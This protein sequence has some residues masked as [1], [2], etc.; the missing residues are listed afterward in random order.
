MTACRVAK[1]GTSIMAQSVSRK[2]L[3][4]P[5]NH[6]KADKGDSADLAGESRLEGGTTQLVDPTPPL[7]A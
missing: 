3:A 4:A 5:N 1:L 7:A 6:L 2:L